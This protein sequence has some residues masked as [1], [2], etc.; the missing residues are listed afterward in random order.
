MAKRVIISGGGT[1]GHIFPA[2]AIANALKTIDPQIE[3][4]FVGAHGKMEMEKVPAAGYEGVDKFFPADKLLLT[5]NPIRRASVE[6]AGKREEALA[7]YGLKPTQKTILVTGGSL[8]AKTLNNCVQASLAHL[9]NLGIQVIWQCGSY[10]YEQLKQEL[11]LSE[12]VKLLPFLQRMDYAY[13]AADIIIARAGAGTIS[14]LCVVGKAAIL[15]PSPNVAEDHQ[16]K[17]ALS[18]VHQQAALMV[19]DIEA[20]A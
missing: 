11:T 8:G 17:N 5:G 3:I 20:A 1:G 12:G 7:F 10:Y 16:T 14:E 19:K 15:V 6:I 4:L 2:V 9:E 13:A 18:L